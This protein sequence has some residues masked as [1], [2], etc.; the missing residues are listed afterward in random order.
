[1]FGNYYYH[2]RT[3]RSV[4]VFGKI[5]NDIYVVRKNSSG[6]AISSVKV[7]L[8]YAPRQKFLDRIR[9]QADLADGQRV[10]IKLPRMSFEITSMAY[11]PTRQL[12]K[13]Q[14]FQQSATV[15]SKR[16]KI[17][18]HVPYLVDFD[19]SIYAKTQDDA[20]QIVEQ[21]LPYFAPQYTVTIKPIDAYPNIKE[22]VPITLTG[23][24]F[25]DDFE[26]PVE[27]RRTIIYTLS[28]QM[29]INFYGPI[30]DSNIITKAIPKIDIDGKG[31]ADSDTLTI[32]ITPTPDGVSAD[33]DY[34]FLE[35]YEYA[36]N[37]DSSF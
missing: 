33:S 15:A 37:S 26:G 35:K 36:F 28:F 24:N 2:E 3:R 20:L 5:F 17:N 12:Q 27:A 22:D 16:A 21:I 29:K 18:M 4:A 11:D 30:N 7:P 1:M 13:N 9:E 31:I 8:A 23:V 14:Q 25:S 6:A 34:G 19:L 32:T 10:A